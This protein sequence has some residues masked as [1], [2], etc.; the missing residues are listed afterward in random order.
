MTRNKAKCVLVVDDEPMVA[1]TLA[2]I[3][4]KHGFDATAVYS[5]EAAVEAA[6][7][8]RPDVLI[9]DFS[10]GAM[11]G[12]EAAIRISAT[13]PDCRLILFSGNVTVATMLQE[14]EKQIGHR[15]EVLAKPLHPAGLLARLAE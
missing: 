15:F 3:L 11:N 13:C 14:V 12:M 7:A 10:M 5:G 2:L 8:L 6:A 1:D 4:R 9:T